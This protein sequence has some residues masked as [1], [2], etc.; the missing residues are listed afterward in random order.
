[1][2]IECDVLVVGGGPA[3]SS[4]AFFSKYFDKENNY[5]V[6]LLER[7]PEEK[8]SAYHDICG[9]CISQQ[10]FKEINPIKPTNIIE[11]IKN[12][13][14]YVGDQY[15]WKYKINGYIIDRPKFFRGILNRYKKMDGIFKQARVTDVEQQKEIIKIKTDKNETIRTKFLI[16][17]DGANSIIRKQF[18]I[19]EN[20]KT[21]TIQ[22]IVNEEPEHESLKFYYDEKF[23][24]DYKY[25]FPNGSTTRIG[26]PLI[27]GQKNDID[28]KIIKKQTR[29]IGC[30]GIKNY[31]LNNIL[32]IGDAAGQTNI[33]S[34]GGIRPGMYAGKKAAEAL[35]VHNNPKKYEEDWKKTGFHNEK[36]IEVFQKIKK[37][38]NKELLDHYEPFEGNN[39]ISG[40]LKTAIFK[41]Y[42]KYR[43]IY[44]AYMDLEKYGW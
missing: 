20:H 8:Y 31:I 4:A 43:D 23:K 18:K 34:K 19:G 10:T 12:I 13:K 17:A 24:G 14:E 3:G 7:L 5:K 35:V 16:A 30:G 27:K 33:L 15:I 37:M 42:S 22:Y 39:K 36:L 6:L 44:D 40:L 25:I 38:N 32:F 29:V 1:M 28:G 26:F 2:T 11:N 41:K 9:C 21:L